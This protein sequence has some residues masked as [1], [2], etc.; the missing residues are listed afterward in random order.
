MW[1]NWIWRYWLGRLGRTAVFVTF[2]CLL[3]VGTTAYIV[4]G[5]IKALLREYGIRLEENPFSAAEIW[6]S[7]WDIPLNI[8]PMD[9]PAH[10][11]TG[12]GENPEN[13]TNLSEE[14]NEAVSPG[15]GTEAESAR[16]TG[17][18]PG[19]DAGREQ[20]E[21]G[22]DPLQGSGGAE[23]AGAD[24]RQKAYDLLL[25]R[26]S[27]EQLDRL[28]AWLRDGLTEEEATELEAM[29]RELFTEEELQQIL[30]ILEPLDDRFRVY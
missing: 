6:N 25:G 10:A 30:Q 27:A 18:V 15:H 7:I 19:G 16:E 5:Y 1:K 22:E 9:A 23:D 3:C 17:E 2:V 20:E 21:P 13:G 4:N 8:K 29:L 28:S 24:Q 14:S 26:L 12:G 11:E